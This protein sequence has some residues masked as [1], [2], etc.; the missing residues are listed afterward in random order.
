ADAEPMTP[1]AWENS[2]V[3]APFEHGTAQTMFRRAANRHRWM[4]TQPGPGSACHFFAGLWHRRWTMRR[5]N[6]QLAA[7]ILQTER[8]RRSTPTDEKY[9]P[10]PHHRHSA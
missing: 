6:S 2:Q 7:T 4:V 10:R 3:R 9:H 1:I 8:S 5:L